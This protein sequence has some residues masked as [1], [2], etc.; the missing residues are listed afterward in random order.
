MNNNDLKDEISALKLEIE[1][2]RNRFERNQREFN[3]LVALGV[4]MACADKDAEIR[5]LQGLWRL[6][7][8]DA[9]EKPKPTEDVL[10]ILDG[11]FWS[12]GSWN[13][14][15]WSFDWGEIKG[16]GEKDTWVLF[17]MRVPEVPNE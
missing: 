1:S 10:V 14:G 16:N 17:W 3:E 4:M 6:I 9:E 2:I 5:R 8:A 12:R 11:D 15:V 7:P 13:N